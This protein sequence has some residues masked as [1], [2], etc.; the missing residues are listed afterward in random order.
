M[1]IL[2]FAGK[3]VGLAVLEFLLERR[4][5]VSY[6]A[7]ASDADTAIMERC[8]EALLPHGVFSSE[9]A[10]FL[11]GGDRRFGW[12]INA[13]SPH[14]LR[15]P[16]L[17][18]ADR[19]ANLH[20]SLVPHCRGSDST[21]WSLREGVTPGVSI[22]EITERVDAGGIYAQT[23]VEIGFPTVASDLHLRLQREM[24]ALFRSAWPDMLSGALQARPQATGGSYHLRRETNADRVKPAE[25]VMTLGEA[26]QWMLA[27]DFAPGTTAELG[28]NGER[29]SVRVLVE[30][31]G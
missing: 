20:P 11:A 8:R 16:L 23:P 29:F 5:P 10:A 9:I 27:H 6:V 2:L 17:A 7:V 24:V 19:R 18:L 25:T 15:A 12:L 31:I 3:T 30:K 26:I 22:I 21:A 13:W 1:S 28:R 14:I 4:D